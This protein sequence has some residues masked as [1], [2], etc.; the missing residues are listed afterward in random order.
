MKTLTFYEN[1]Y[2]SN[3]VIPLEEFPLW[4]M[5]ARAELCRITFGRFKNYAESEKVMFCVCEVAE[6]MYTASRNN[7]ILSESN[8]GY[9]VTYEKG[10]LGEKTLGTAKLYLDE[11]LFYRGI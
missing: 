8:D 9:S 7:N 5:R 11:S 3:A 4:E 2:G 6:A 1:K 10:D